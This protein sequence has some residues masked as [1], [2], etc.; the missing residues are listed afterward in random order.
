MTGFGHTD[1]LAEGC[2]LQVDIKSVNHRYSEV[3]IRM[4]REW[5]IWES[6]LKKIIQ[7]SVR[8]GRVDVFIS[9]EGDDAARKDAVIDWPLAEAYHQAAEQL[10]QRFGLSGSIDLSDML[11]LPELVA[12]RDHSEE[13]EARIGQVLNEMVQEAMEQLL[14]MRKAEGRHLFADLSD[15]FDKLQGW[16]AQMISLAPQVAEEYRAKL[17]QRMDAVLGEAVLDENRLVAE[18]AL[19]ADRSNI[20]EEL[21]RLR[22]HFQQGRTLL[23]SDESVG[24]KL[25]FIVQE[26][27]RE[28]NTIGSKAN[29]L[30]LVR[31]VVEMKAE[32]EK[33][34]EQVQNIE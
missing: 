25:D 2:R 17:R 32:L 28:V 8:R 15:R 21:T 14:S 24:R 29:H 33:I 5:M 20:D 19:F 6:S 31:L 18:V 22:S 26:M 16:A 3:M 11:G 27:N 10:K 30:E 13:A 4:P 12:F 7:Q 1:R 23:S 34:R 9:C